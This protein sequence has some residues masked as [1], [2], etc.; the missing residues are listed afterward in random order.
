MCS[1]GVALRLRVRRRQSIDRDRS[2]TFS[3]PSIQR[4]IACF[5]NTKTELSTMSPPGAA[6][7]RLS[8]ERITCQGQPGTLNVFGS[9][10]RCT[11]LPVILATLL[12]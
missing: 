5:H 8:R 4:L 12:S 7:G 1:L 11:T 3:L 10:K 6:W 9:R 2:A